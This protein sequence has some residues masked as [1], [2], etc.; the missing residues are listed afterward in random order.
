MQSIIL[1]PLSITIAL[2]LLIT[3]FNAC[4]TASD[5]QRKFEDEAFSRPEGYTATDRNGNIIDG[6]ED[7]DDWRIAPLFRGYVQ[8]VFTPAFPNPVP[9][10]VD[11]VS[12]EIL[13]EM[14]NSVNSMILY[15]YDV[16]GNRRILSK[17]QDTNEAKI[18]EFTFR[19]NELSNIGSG[20]SIPDL[21]RV[22]LT[23]GNDDLITYGDIMIE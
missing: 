1:R 10:N 17:I 20:G 12:I 23:D 2:F 14:P 9:P 22:F 11:N 6:Q 5:D 21:Y 19:P 18:Y 4:N 15:G 16:N 13:I 7:P 3:A 8:E